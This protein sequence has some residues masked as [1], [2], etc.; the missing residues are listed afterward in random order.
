[1][2]LRG[3]EPVVIED[4][5]GLF[6]R[7]DRDS[8][9]LDH[10][11]DCDNVKFIYSGIE[12]RDGLQTYRAVGNPVRIHKYTLQNDNGQSILILN[13]QGQIFHS[14]DIN[15]VLGPILTIPLMTDFNIVA[16]AGRA[17]ITPFT[18]YFDA[19]TN[20]A[21]EKGLTGEFVYVY[22]GD[23]TA[24]RKMAGAGPTNGGDKPF[25]AF[26]SETDG[27]IAQGVHV[28]AIAFGDAGAGI[29]SALGPE[30]RQVVLAPGG[31]QIHLNNIPIGGGGITQRFVYATKV[32]DPKDFNPDL[33]T[34]LYYRVTT[35]PD[36]TTT[37]F[38]I[39]FSEADLTVVFAAGVLGVPTDGGALRVANTSVD[40]HT[41]FGLHVIGVVYETDTGYLTRPGP[42]FFAAVTTIDIKKAIT[43]TNIP[44]S[45]DSFVTKRHLIATQAILNFNG[46]QVGFQFFFIPDGNIDDNTTTT[47]T[48]S[49]YDSELLDDASHLLENFSEIAA[50]VGLTTYHGRLILNTQFSD[51]SLIRVSHSGEP[52]SISEVDG[53]VIIPLDGN[54]L[55]VCQEL[56]DVLYACKTVR[57]AAVSDNGD[58][59]SSWPVI[60]LEQGIGAPVHGISTVLDSG[61]VNVDY[62]I[63]TSV[64]GVV[65]FNG[66]YSIPE[67]SWKIENYWNV[68]EKN[69]FRFIQ[70]MNDTINKL[71]WISLPNRDLLMGDY[72]NGLDPQ[73]IRWAPATFDIEVTT[74][75]LIERDRLIIGAL[76]EA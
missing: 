25:I 18:T 55:T 66:T 33:T 5:N 15:T 47:K 65:I 49:F 68:L 9:P 46:D 74:I 44:V 27:S 1:M 70:I 31:K 41:D 34:Y 24:A 76:Q 71:L 53:L 37:N 54:P 4:F 19:I 57:T 45:P 52:E 3:H 58:V 14:P 40:G 59:P 23:G 64:I 6:S 56:R 16:I 10:S 67:L 42:E 60:M 17:Y 7:G 75:A 11:P 22:K 35:I 50:G 69:D 39:D 62:L 29:S 32:I 63:M 36:N 72:K 8:C 38:D 48:V 13:N 30:I 2:V 12:T 43:V 28:I 51:I 61:G 73:N 20:V 21:L 26:N